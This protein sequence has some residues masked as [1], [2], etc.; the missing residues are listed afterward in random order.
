MVTGV[1]DPILQ[2][3][4]NGLKGKLDANSA[5][6]ADNYYLK[7]G[8]QVRISGDETIIRCAA[9]ETPHGVALE[10]LHQTSVPPTGI[11][12]R[13]RVSWIPYAYNRALV[14]GVADG[15]LTAGDYCTMGAAAGDYK[16]AVA[17]TATTPAGSTPVTSSEAQPAM[18]IAGTLPPIREIAL[19][20]KG[21]TNNAAVQVLI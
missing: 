10:S 11:D 21:G 17:M 16:K 7:A 5:V 8:E 18:T 14:R 9:G 6:D 4:R 19:C 12:S 13:V 15:P 20:W 3:P 1:Y 2:D